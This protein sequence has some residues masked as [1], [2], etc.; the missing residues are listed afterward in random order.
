MTSYSAEDWKSKAIYEE[1]AKMA[2]IKRI[3]LIIQEY[4]G[5]DETMDLL[6]LLWEHGQTEDLRDYHDRP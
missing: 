4:P 5:T 1:A 3:R 6:D 2:V